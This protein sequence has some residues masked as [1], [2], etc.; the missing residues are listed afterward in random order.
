MAA[1]SKE[2]P[3]LALH[4]LLSVDLTACVAVTF[5]AQKLTSTLA[6]LIAIVAD[7]QAH[8]DAHAAASLAETAAQRE[9]INIILTTLEKQSGTVLKPMKAAKAVVVP[10]ARAAPVAAGAGVFF[11][12]FIVYYD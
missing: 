5:D 7:Q 11:L 12:F 4:D 8:I 2:Q 10:K 3:P 6:S 1:S 9:Q